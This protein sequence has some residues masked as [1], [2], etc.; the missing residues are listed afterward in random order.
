[1]SIAQLLVST[2]CEAGTETRDREGMDGDFVNNP[3]GHH[4]RK[5]AS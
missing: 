3:Q 1:M 2:F 5:R 4:I